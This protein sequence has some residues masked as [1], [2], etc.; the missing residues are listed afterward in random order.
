MD[1]LEQLREQRNLFVTCPNCGDDFRLAEARL[2][3]ATKRL[4][5]YAQ[6]YLASQYAGLK[7]Q[8]A[9]LRAS[10]WRLERSLGS[11]PRM[12]EWVWCWRMSCHRCRD[13]Q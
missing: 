13:S 8:R 1:I 10:G 12:R 6:A 7:E 2:F 9:D 11:R 3:D 5:K 4:P